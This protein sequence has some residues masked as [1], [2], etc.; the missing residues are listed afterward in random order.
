MGISIKSLGEH[1]LS[2]N[3]ICTVLYVHTYC[4]EGG[5]RPPNNTCVSQ[6]F[7][8]YNQLVVYLF[9]FLRTFSMFMHA[10][11]KKRECEVRFF[12]VL[13]GEEDHWNSAVHQM[14]LLCRPT[15]P[16]VS[17]GQISL[18]CHFT[19]VWKLIY[20]LE[21]TFMH[22]IDCCWFLISFVF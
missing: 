4:W 13:R 12:S 9:I 5:G 22:V 7:T 16:S 8:T 2:R 11:E 17:L 1:V 19:Q 14:P 3:F 20:A 21:R 6:L 18:F 15:P 10:K